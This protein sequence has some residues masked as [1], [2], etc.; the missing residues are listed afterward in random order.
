MNPEIVSGSPKSESRLIMSPETMS[1]SLYGWESSSVE[2]PTEMRGGGRDKERA[3]TNG[4]DRERAGTK[5]GDR[6]RVGTKGGTAGGEL[7]ISRR[8]QRTGEHGGRGGEGAGREGTREQRELATVSPRREVLDIGSWRPL[9]REE[10]KWVRGELHLVSNNLN[11]VS[12]DV[13]RIKRRL[14]ELDRHRG[15]SLALKFRFFF[16]KT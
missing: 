5:G 16:Y 10:D 7:D 8:R 9:A 6:E 4:G 2:T 3:G 1:G 15:Q 11:S 14:G 12:R 13:T